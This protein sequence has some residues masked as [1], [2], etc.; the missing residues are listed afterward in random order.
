MTGES[1][2]VSMFVRHVLC[3]SL[4]SSIFAVVSDFLQR[5]KACVIASH[6]ASRI[7]RSENVAM[8][9]AWLL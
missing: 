3:L 2:K 5:R 9:S 1:G 7:V 4:N 8:R 6:R